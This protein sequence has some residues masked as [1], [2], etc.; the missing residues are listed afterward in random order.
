M[1]GD[2]YGCTGGCWRPGSPRPR[3]ALDWERL[4]EAGGLAESVPEGRWSGMVSAEDSE[5]SPGAACAPPARRNDSLE[6][7]GSVE[8]RE[9]WKLVWNRVL[10]ERAA[11]EY[12]SC[13]KSAMPATWQ[14]QKIIVSREGY[15]TREMITREKLMLSESVRIKCANLSKRCKKAT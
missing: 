9:F 7:S 14:M 15:R 6:I 1:T 4:R 8:S 12:I 11:G 2:W 3:D 10:G 5:A 13:T